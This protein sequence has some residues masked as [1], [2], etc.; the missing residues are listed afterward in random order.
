[1]NNLFISFIFV[2]V[3]FLNAISIFLSDINKKLEIISKTDVV[4]VSSAE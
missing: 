2:T 1:M 3:G 4:L